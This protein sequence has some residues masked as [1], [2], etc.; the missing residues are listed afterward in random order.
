M[1]NRDLSIVGIAIVAIAYAFY[2]E[3]SVTFRQSFQVVFSESEQGSDHTFP[4]PVVGDLNNDGT[5]EVVLLS[6]SDMVSIVPTSLLR[7]SY[8]NNFLDVTPKYLAPLTSPCIGLNIGKTKVNGT[9]VVAVITNDYVVTLMNNDL[10]ERWSVRIPDIDTETFVPTHASVIV[11]PQAI[12][13]GDEGV[14][15][16]GV[17][18]VPDNH[19]LG[20]TH[21]SYYAFHTRDGAL[22]WQHDATSFRDAAN[23]EQR[24]YPH[25][26]FKLTTKDLEEHTTEVDWRTFR[27]SILASLPHRHDHPWDTEFEPRFFFKQKNKKKRAAV[28]GGEEIKPKYH[29]KARGTTNEY[30]DL[31]ARLAAA[32]SVT[33]TPKKVAPHNPNVLVVHTA[34]GLEVLH[35]YT[36]RTICQVGPL[37]PHVTYDDFNLDSVIDAAAPHISRD[38]EY[39]FGSVKE[40]TECLGVVSTNV[41]YTNEVIYRAP[42]CRT[43]IGIHLEMMMAFLRGNED[44]DSEDGLSLPGWGTT[45]HFDPSTTTTAPTSVHRKVRNGLGIE[46]ISHDVVF[47]LNTGYL[48]SMDVRTRSIRWRT[49]TPAWFH[50]KEQKEETETV[51]DQHRTQPYPHTT[52]YNPVAATYGKGFADPYVLAVGVESLV[53]VHVG[54]GNIEDTLYLAEPPVAPVVVADFNTDGVMDLVVLTKKGVFG[55]LGV[56]RQGYNALPYL[57]LAVLTVVIALVASQKAPGLQDPWAWHYATGG[58]RS[59]D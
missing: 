52:V 33:K 12:Y 26:S 13:D 32:S 38:Q 18:T 49:H 53:L 7:R 39:N 3:H 25:Q 31:G 8:D 42:I 21:F 47:H 28:R 57:L 22:R 40:V 14:V 17:D 5:N 37:R 19:T 6:A 59:T 51:S 44:D 50:G 29:T 58:K 45:D 35:L 1:R 2:Q 56:Q 43:G 30:G 4:R 11:L 41:P 34:K 15:I 10:T 9:V 54:S 48:T 55:Y 24:R 27:E 36:G 46:R 20:G 23:V 16:V